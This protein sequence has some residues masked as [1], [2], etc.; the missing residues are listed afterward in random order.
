MKRSERHLKPRNFIT[1]VKDVGA[2]KRTHIVICIPGLSTD[3]SWVDNARVRARY[4][5][6]SIEFIKITPTAQL[7]LQH[8]LFG[9]GLSGI[10]ND[11]SKKITNLVLA[12][13]RTDVQISLLAHSIGCGIAEK[14]IRDIHYRFK[15]IIFI[16]SICHRAHS[17]PIKQKCTYF[18]NSCGT[19]DRWPVYIEA[20]NF[21]KYSATGTVGFGNSAYVNDLFYETDHH[22]CTDRDHIETVIVPLL[23]GNVVEQ[24]ID[25]VRSYS[26]MYILGL[27]SIG[28]FVI[29][30]LFS[31]IAVLFGYLR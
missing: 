20:V 23:M 10:E 3:G 31:L 9:I 7:W 12:H 25:P 24:P 15:Y 21:W 30:V 8:V 16:G 19:K 28:L 26:R 18:I 22:S 11:I 1:D 4:Y 2:P 29:C 6:S 5:N 27:K 13:G 17:G 14:V